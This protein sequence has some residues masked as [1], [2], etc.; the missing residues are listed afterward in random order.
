[1]VREAAERVVLALPREDV[2][3][4]IV[5]R[6]SRYSTTDN[7]MGRMD[8]P[9]LL[10]SNR[11]QLASVSAS[12]HFEPII[13]LRR[14]PVSAIWRTMSTIVVYFSCLAASRSIRPKAGPC[15]FESEGFPNA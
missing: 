7:P 5:R 4:D 8:S 1:M 3:P 11:K 14:E 9:S 12:V 10:S 13:S 15:G 6:R 2:C